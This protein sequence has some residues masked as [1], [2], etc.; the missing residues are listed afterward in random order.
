VS[1][2]L[3]SR[4]DALWF[5]LVLLGEI[6]GL[7]VALGGPWIEVSYFLLVVVSQTIAGAYI[8]AHLRKHE[9]QLPIPE[10]LAMG[11]AIGSSSAAISQLILRDLLGSRL[12]ISPYVPIIAVAIWLIVKRSPKLDVE[13]THTD[14][15]TLLWLLFPAPLALSHYVW[16][17]LPIYLVPLLIFVFSLHRSE[18]IWIARNSKKL[19]II[20][21]V[22]LAIA[23]NFTISVLTNVSPAIGLAEADL[24][25]DVGHSVTFANF[26]VDENIGMVGQNFQYYKFS[27]LWLGPTLLTTT[28]VGISVAT[29]I[30]PLLFFLMIGMALWALTH[31]FSKSNRAANISSMLFYALA[32]IPEPI[33]LEIRIAYLFPYLILLCGGLIVLKH[34]TTNT[35]TSFILISLTVFAVTYSRIF[36]LPALFAFVLAALH[37]EL[38]SI[39]RIV[40]RIPFLLGANLVGSLVAVYFI[41]IAF[42]PFVLTGTDRFSLVSSAVSFTSVFLPFLLLI[43]TGTKFFKK[44]RLI[45]FF[46]FC[47]SLAML[48]LHIFGPRKYPSTTFYTLTLAICLS[49]VIAILIDAE[50]KSTQTRRFKREFFLGTAL[51]FGFVFSAFYFVKQYIGEPTSGPMRIYWQLFL[52]PSQRPNTESTG[53]RLQIAQLLIVFFISGFGAL[54]WRIFGMRFRQVLVVA[55]VAVMFGNSIAMTTREFVRDPS[56]TSPALIFDEASQ[57]R[58]WSNLSRTVGL[59]NARSLIARRST[60]ATNFGNYESDGPNDTYIVAIELRARSYLSP[61]YPDPTVENESSRELSYLVATRKFISINFPT[62][63]DDLMLRDL[64]QAGVKWF[65]IDLERTE[66][67]DWEPWATTRFINDKVAILELATDIEG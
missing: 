10:L 24:L 41:L 58:R 42:D 43:I 11:F 67:R 26:G 31:Y 4:N 53:L 39:K 32:T 36:L 29:T 22:L 62:Q 3:K 64:Q 46:V 1:L 9:H 34:A 44:S 12:M 48:F 18:V 19:M 40:H 33:I 16:L 55:T 2:T 30:V 7:S 5:C 61:S 37:E 8:W 21:T 15:T 23:T 51:I 28:E 60:I 35:V 13:I 56:S 20:S 25:F 65:I 57:S 49:S 66:L 47:I 6:F 38:G 14:S 45:L 17:L 59:D 54:A 50:L 27:H 52:Q 63:P